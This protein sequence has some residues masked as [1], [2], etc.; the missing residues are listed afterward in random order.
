VTPQRYLNL[1]VS[2]Y[3]GCRP[4]LKILS[5]NN[6]SNFIY[7]KNFVFCENIF[8]ILSQVCCE[9]SQWFRIHSACSFI[10]ISLEFILVFS[11]QLIST[12]MTIM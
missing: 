11:K 5:S 3:E 12:F 7:Q 9:T 6:I 2:M 1:T 4:G 8:I 10:S